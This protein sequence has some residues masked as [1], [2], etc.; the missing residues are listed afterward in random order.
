MIN[1]SPE[2][3]GWIAKI[4]VVGGEGGKVEGETEGLM[5]KEKYEEF[6][7]DE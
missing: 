7:A 6:T 2:E 1:K 4:E 5:D 3:E